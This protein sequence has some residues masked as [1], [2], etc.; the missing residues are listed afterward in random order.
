MRTQE[1]INHYLQDTTI[2]NARNLLNIESC[3]KNNNLHLPNNV[4]IHENGVSFTEFLKW[5]ENR[6][7]KAGDVV[8]SPSGNI[9]LI[10]HIND[11]NIIFYHC[12][13]YIFNSFKIGI[14][15]GIG[16]VSECCLASSLQKYRLFKAIYDAG[17]QYN[18]ETL[19]D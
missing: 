12:I 2:K 8:V 5:F 11:K 9:V 17:Y 18:I 19:F 14:D 10:S 16:T 7:F 13:L 3:I 15:C 6:C 4:I 1:E